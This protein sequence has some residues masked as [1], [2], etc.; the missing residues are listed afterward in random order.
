MC[1]TRSRSGLLV[2][3][4]G[5][6]L[7]FLPYTVSTAF[8]QAIVPAASLTELSA[9][10]VILKDFTVGPANSSIHIFPVAALAKSVSPLLV[11]AA[12]VPSGLQYHAGGQI[13]PSVTIYTI[14]WVPPKLQTGAATAMST[15][16][17]AL[18]MRLLQDYPGHGIHNNLTQYYQKIGAST[19]YVQNV[20]SFGGSYVDTSP[21]P[22][23]AC[24]NTNTP[25]NCITDAQLRAEIQKVMS[26][27]NWQGGLNK[28]YFLYTSSGEGSCS[29]GDATS[30]SYSQ[31][32]AYHSFIPGSP[33]I[34]YANMPFGDPKLCQDGTPPSPNGDPAADTA[35]TAASHELS[36]AI[37]DPLENAWFGAQGTEIGDL[38]AYKYGAMNWGNN[39]ANQ[40]W[41][42]NLYLVQQEWDNHINACAPV[43][44]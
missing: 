35:S 27:K 36:E 8:S 41:N 31:Y 43:G 33:P 23:S 16:Y 7:A 11:A 14:F 13:M 22:S 42:G 30:C 25:G 2:V 17:Q 28:I 40:M 34:I 9:K 24:N 3:T 1:K 20:G 6:L 4:T 26:L 5:A 38:C 39:N 19:T 32:C 37:T 12:G 29:N 10:G 21:Y 18:Q 44:P 15:G